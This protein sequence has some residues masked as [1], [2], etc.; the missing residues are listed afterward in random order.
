MSQLTDRTLAHLL[1]ALELTDGVVEARVDVLYELLEP[2][3][4]TRGF[5]TRGCLT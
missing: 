4:A 3:P 5:T 1:L 2:L